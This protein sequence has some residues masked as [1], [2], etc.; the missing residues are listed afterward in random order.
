MR[1]ILYSL[2]AVLTMACNPQ[3][4]P[5]TVSSVQS[6]ACSPSAIEPLNERPC[7]KRNLV[8]TCEG[9]RV[10]ATREPSLLKSPIME[11]FDEETFE[12][13]QDR[14]VRVRHK[15]HGAKP[16]ETGLFYDADGRRSMAKWD[17]TIGDGSKASVT[18]RFE[19]DDSGRLEW[20]R[21]TTTSQYLIGGDTHYIF[22]DAGRTT[23][24]DFFQ[25]GVITKVFKYTYD[26]NGRRL[27]S[28]TIWGNQNQPVCRY[29]P[30][31]PAPYAGCV[32]NCDPVTT[33]KHK[34]PPG[35]GRGSGL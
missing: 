16:A 17:G 23:Q 12:Y 2:A 35:E 33:K 28:Q 30:P 18:T 1:G 32:A 14:L 4:P 25:A 24:V 10:V 20:E 21:T 11:T 31:C 13:A 6:G 3:S 22:D 27:T 7:G 29:E 34:T 9:G 8:C 15:V 5:D 19:Y 26:A